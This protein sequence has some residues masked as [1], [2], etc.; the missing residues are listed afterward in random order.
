MRIE[1]LASAQQDL[2][3]G[4]GF[5][6]KQEQGLGG[7]FL[8]SLF[9]DIDSLQ[10]HAGVHPL[11]FRFHRLLSKRFPFAIYYRMRGDSA[12]VFAVLDCRRNPAWV[13]EKLRG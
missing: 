7:Y 4:Y 8:D 3:E 13:R 1:I 10:I 5:Y 12:L 6:E 9:S 2:I 11:H